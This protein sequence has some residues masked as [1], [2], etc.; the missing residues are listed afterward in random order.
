MTNP[1]RLL[2]SCSTRFR[3]APNA[4]HCGQAAGGL[5]PIALRSCYWPRGIRVLGW[6]PREILYPANVWVVSSFEYRHP[7]TGIGGA[8]A[9]VARRADG[10]FGRANASARRMPVV[11]ADC[12]PSY[13]MF[14]LLLNS[15]EERQALIAHLKAQGILSVFHYVPLHLSDMGRK[16]GA[17]PGDCPVTEEVSERLLRLPFYNDLSEGDQARVVSAVTGFRAARRTTAIA[18]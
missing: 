6:E 11:P 13:H 18:S 3:P 8:I 15:L 5:R 10:A 16:F 14:Y 1:V 7:E 4:T 17:Q 9:S 12:E 2:K